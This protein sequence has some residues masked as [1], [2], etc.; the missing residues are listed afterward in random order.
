MEEP[1]PKPLSSSMVQVFEWTAGILNRKIKSL[2][3]SVHIQGRSGANPT[4]VRGKGYRA[5]PTTSRSFQ[6]G[7]LVAP[8]DFTVAFVHT[9][10]LDVPHVPTRELSDRD[11]TGP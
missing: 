8:R 10:P 2:S 11:I 3:G 9:G 1:R 7:R 4:N 5:V 6:A